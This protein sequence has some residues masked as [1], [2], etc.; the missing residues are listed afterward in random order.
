MYPSSAIS[1]KIV[2]NRARKVMG[3]YQLALDLS[4]RR[5]GK[6]AILVL[7]NRQAAS[8]IS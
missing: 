5:E 8:C 4:N 1:G 7:Y 2:G 3:K 6:H